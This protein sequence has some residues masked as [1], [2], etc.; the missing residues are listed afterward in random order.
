MKKPNIIFILSDDQ[1]AWAMNCAGNTDII[2]PNLNRLAEKGVLFENFFCASPV[3]SPARASIVTGTLPSYHGVIDWL[4]GGNIDAN[5][6]PEL[7]DRCNK[8]NDVGVEYLDGKPFYVKELA[9][10]GYTCAH[11]GKWHLGAN[12]KIKNGYTKWSAL[13][14][15]G[16]SY[17]VPNIFEDGKFTC[18]NEYVTDVITEKALEYLDDLSKEENPFYLS[19]HYT[20]PHSPW[21]EENHPKK[22]L[23]MYRDSEFNF[24]PKLPLHKNQI[25]SAPIATN[26]SERRDN[27][28]GYYAAITAM[29][30]NIGKILDKLE[31]SGKLEDTVIIFT[32]DNGMNLGHHG[33]WGKGNGTYPQ[34]MYDTSVK[35]PFIISAP[36]IKEENK[37]YHNLYSHC[38]IFQTILEIADIKYDNS[39]EQPGTSFYRNLCEGEQIENRD[40]LVCSEY[41]AVRMLRTN[42]KK[43][44]LD[45]KNHENFFFDLDKDPNEE[46]NLINNSAYQTEIQANKEKLE[47]LFTKY[48]STDNDAR[49]FAV[50]GRGQ[51]NMA[52]KENSFVNRIGFVNEDLNEK[53]KL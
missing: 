12:D 33:I 25:T 18:H 42:S 11:S 50:S 2:T 53:Y 7:K 17:F 30:E 24:T 35:I 39:Q 5:K 31:Q 38:D 8:K 21:D 37:I 6:Y 13:E 16:C 41:G 27:L 34:N 40:V 20:A 49:Q 19:V 47:E 43:L 1:G 14:G 3:C 22:Y 52:T 4:S 36:F 26:E 32:A 44:V 10:G 29:D 48:S 9:D 51:T 45:Y 28:R 15:G 46:N 23:D